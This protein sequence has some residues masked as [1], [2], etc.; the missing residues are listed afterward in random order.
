MKD[1][2]SAQELHH[3]IFGSVLDKSEMTPYLLREAG[4]YEKALRQAAKMM[5]NRGF[6]MFGSNELPE[7]E[8]NQGTKLCPA[9]V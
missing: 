3:E 5:G 8:K 2:S 9:G 7:S 4:N 1:T 6:D